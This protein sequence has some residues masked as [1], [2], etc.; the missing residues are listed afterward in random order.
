[1]HVIAV[2]LR[3]S[4]CY[5]IPISWCPQRMG[6]GFSDE[7]GW[8]DIDKHSGSPSHRCVN[9]KIQRPHWTNK[10]Q[11]NIKGSQTFVLES[12]YETPPTLRPSPSGCEPEDPGQQVFRSERSWCFRKI[13]NYSE[14]LGEVMTPSRGSMTAMSPRWWLRLRQ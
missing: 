6:P 8:A 10:S 11:D 9:V 12:S 14:L 7:G 2:L 3:P 13:P 4:G 5:I 1:M